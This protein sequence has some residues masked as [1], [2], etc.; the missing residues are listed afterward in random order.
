MVLLGLCNTPIIMMFD[1]IYI[2]KTIPKSINSYPEQLQMSNMVGW[3][4]G[5]NHELGC[6][7]VKTVQWPVFFKY[8]LVGRCFK[9]FVWETLKI[10]TTLYKLDKAKK[11]GDSSD[12]DPHNKNYTTKV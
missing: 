10:I 6:P 1:T 9:R 8:Q 2:F 5:W 11:D 12:T 7:C 3:L 4:V